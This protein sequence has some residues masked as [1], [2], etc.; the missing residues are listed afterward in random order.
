M[1]LLAAFTLPH[2][3][4][5]I[6]A[7][8]KGEEVKIQKTLDAF[9]EIAGQ[10]AKL[11][12]ETIIFI[13]PHNTSYAD[14]F[15]ISPGSE[16]SGDFA[17][18]NAR[19]VKIAKKYDQELASA[20][21]TAASDA[22]IMA[23]GAGERDKRLDHGV[24]VPMWYIDKAYPDYMCVRIS[25]SGFS[26]K[27]HY[28]FGQCLN[29]AADKLNRR[30]V[31]VA[32]GDLSHKLKEEGPYG[33]AKEGPEYDKRVTEILN[34]ADFL[35]LLQIPESALESAAECGYRSYAVMAGCFD[36]KE[37][38]SKLIS[39]EGP[40]GV[41]YAVSSFYPEG[42]RPSRNFFEQLEAIELDEAR[43]REEGEDAYRSLARKSLEFRVKNGK[44]LKLS[45]LEMDALPEEMTTERAGVFVSLHLSGRL[46]GC[47]GTI[48]PA[49]GTIAE[50]I[51]SNAVSA[52]MH[53]NRFT[54]VMADELKFLTYKV[55]VLKP[56]EDISDLTQ[57]DP[58]RYGVIV[59]EGGKRG[60][61]LPKLDGVDTAEKQIS[62]AMRK[63]GIK[64]G[65]KISL[66]RFE[67][68][69]HE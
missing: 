45:K 19:D 27:I 38:A 4:L 30:V 13:T 53:D 68:V 67:V 57:L 65:A 64:E 35:S 7:V 6:P 41:G 58:S 46:R 11:K 8:G 62:I 28:K 51:I 2:P 36:K 34:E 54:P 63:A 44:A 37:V 12:P 26:S 40:F 50:E 69:R 39:Y 66:Q 16:A 31:I 56:A 43:Q 32:S 17:K 48:S 52:G 60:L 1:P 49:T 23:G 14:Y 59:S 9:A 20:V 33:F 29:E 61:L 3:P 24:L 25:Q 47:I 21:Q 55:D 5:A 15:H 22:G 42:D 10:I 18:F